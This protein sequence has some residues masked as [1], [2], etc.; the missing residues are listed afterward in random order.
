MGQ[1]TLTVKDGYSVSKVTL[2]VM[3]SNVTDT[4]PFY[5]F[6]SGQPEDLKANETSRTYDLTAFNGFMQ[7]AEG[8]Q[9]ISYSVTNCGVGT[10]V[11]T[12]TQVPTSQT[13]QQWVAS[14]WSSLYNAAQSAYYT[15][16]QAINVQITDLQ[17][18]ISAVD[19]LTLRRE[20]NDEIMKCVLQW[21]LGPAFD[22]MPGEVVQIYAA[23]GS[24]ALDYGVGFTGNELFLGASQ[25]TTMFM[26][27][28][29]VKFIN[30]AIEWENVVYYL[31]SYFWDVP[32]SWSFIRQIQHPD[33]TRQAFLRAGSARVVLTVRPG[34]EQ[35]WMSFVEQGD[36]GLILPPGHPY[37]TIAQQIQAYDSTNYPGIPPADPNGGAPVDDDAPQIGTTCSV[38][39]AASNSPV[40]IPV[41]DSTGFFPG[42]TA[43]IDNWNTNVDP[44]TGIGIQEKQTIV[45][46]P[47]DGKHITVQALSNAHDGTRTPFPVVQAGA[48]GLLIAEWFEYTP[49]SGV[50]IAMTTNTATTELPSP[51]Q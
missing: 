34:F 19:T 24:D 14:V 51:P 21:L 29:M 46:V 12:I 42:A 1:L 49:T 13:M 11:F 44:N 6:G 47:A 39:V 5:V 26:Y 37:F 30:E 3:L 4:R 9:T 16:Q 22:F 17:N 25:W 7:G 20:E 31:Y 41:P 43:I 15:K 27:Q 50:D 18:K 32:T 33:P 10:A 8:S 2:E 23:R 35:A 28:E 48:K 36:F 40:N 38:Q 45:A